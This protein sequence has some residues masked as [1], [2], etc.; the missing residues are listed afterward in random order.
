MRPSYSF[1]VVESDASGRVTS[2]RDVATADLRVNGGGF[3]FRKEIFDVLGSGDE[4]VDGPFAALASQGRLVAY[5]DEGFWVALD[6]LKDLE[7][8]QRLEARDAA[9]WAVGRHP[10]SVPADA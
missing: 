1:H 5:P 9:P 4:L 3:M 8:L 6:T 2:L 7:L 10:D